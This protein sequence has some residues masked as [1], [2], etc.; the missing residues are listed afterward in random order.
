VTWAVTWFGASVGSVDQPSSGAIRG[1]SIGGYLLLAGFGSP[2]RVPVVPILKDLANALIR[3][4]L[5]L[6]PRN[7]G[8]AMD[9]SIRRRPK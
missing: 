7:F 8:R 5:I 1:K 2:G 3:I 4:G 6:I 9:Q